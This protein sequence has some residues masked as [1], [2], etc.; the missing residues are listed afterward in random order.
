MGNIL[1]FVL[2]GAS[3]LLLLLPTSLE[4]QQSLGRVFNP[5]AHPRYPELVAF[6]RIQRDRREIQFKRLDT[7]E[8]FPLSGPSGEPGFLVLPG[9]EGGDGLS[10]FSG[11]L[12]WR[13][14]A[15]R[16]MHWFAYVSSDGNTL[17]LF[18]DYVDLDGQPSQEGPIQVPFDGGVRAPRWS[19]NGR[20]LVFFSEGA[21]FV[22]P[23]VDRV[24][25]GGVTAVAQLR[26]LRLED[27]T[28]PAMFPS[29]SP[30]GD[31]LAY[32]V[33]AT[34]R[35]VRNWAIEV[36]PVNEESAT[37]AG[38]PRVVTQSL[39]ETNE[40]RPSWSADGSYLAYYVDRGGRARSG[41]SS[42]D[43][44]VVEIQL[45]PQT[46][47]IFR[48]EVKQ[49]RSLR[50]A[51]GVLPNEVRG[52]T[53]TEVGDNEERPH[54]AL[55]Y[56]LGD[57]SRF[58]PVMITA[59]DRWLEMLPREEFELEFSSTWE[60]RNHRY[61]S[62]VEMPGTIRYL[63]VAQAVGGETVTYHDANA[64]WA[65]GLARAVLMNPS[66]TAFPSLLIPGFGQM[67][68]R[69][70]ALGLAFLASAGAMV[71]AGVGMVADTK[72]IC[73][74]LL[75]E[76]GD[77]DG[78]VMVLETGRPLLVPSI[79]AAVVLGV[80]SAIHAYRRAVRVNQEGWGD[81]ARGTEQDTRTRSGGLSLSVPSVIPTRYGIDVAILRI[82]F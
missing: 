23:D 59:V 49:G 21:I 56:V 7:G 3:I 1:S 75:N 27:A 18:L 28:T 43:I 17:R 78:R 55:V 61:L 80:V 60:T 81:V 82:Q 38:R 79:G 58:F 70:P 10:V 51:E 26:T 4:G 39:D 33:E 53:W 22:L 40:Y 9:L 24:I 76:A 25:R 54:P 13:A 57:E 12:D 46:D 68:T 20:H 45:D 5:S 67:R 14:Q 50:I 52:P 65:R 6:E 77:C 35:G 19:P 74:D 8:T 31:H 44:G 34:T 48:G 72:G 62:Q 64:P 36:M 11:D 66:A 41:S 73:L 47:R 42:L 15:E 16:G 32:Q 2:T 71:G 63:Y 69:S 29:W 37:V 30:Q